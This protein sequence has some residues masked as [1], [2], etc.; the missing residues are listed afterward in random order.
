MEG[1]D[2]VAIMK[3]VEYVERMSIAKATSSHSLV[4]ANVV[5]GLKHLIRVRT[6]F[7]A[8]RR[9]ECLTIYLL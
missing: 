8:Y 7:L 3:L 4:A 9:V 1:N 5:R 6:I 2:R